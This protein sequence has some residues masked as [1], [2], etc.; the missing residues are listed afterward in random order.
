[1]TV[2]FFVG[3]VYTL[4]TKS[5]KMFQ[6]E[7]SVRVIFVCAMHGC[8]VVYLDPEILFFIMLTL[9]AASVVP[10]EAFM[11]MIL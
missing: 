11:G 3:S 10:V 6:T 1:V 5:V 2:S 7:L 9:Y 4:L 8:M